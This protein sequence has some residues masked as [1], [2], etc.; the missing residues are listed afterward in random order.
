M[1]LTRLSCDV[2][3]I[4][5][6]DQHRLTSLQRSRLVKSTRKLSKI[7]GET[8]ATRITFASLES[9]PHSRDVTQEY[10]PI[11][12]LTNKLARTVFESIQVV[13]RRRQDSDSDGAHSTDSEPCS[14]PSPRG[15]APV[16]L[17]EA[18]NLA[19]VDCHHDDP[20]VSHNES[21]I[22][23]LFRRRRSRLSAISSSESPTE[24]EECEDERGARNR[25]QRLSKLTRYLGESIPSELILPNI[26]SKSKTNIPALTP[27]VVP[28]PS[29][30]PALEQ[31]T[32]FSTTS[33]LP[34]PAVASTVDS[35]MGSIGRSQ[36]HRFHADVNSSRFLVH[37]RRPR[38]ESTLSLSNQPLT[39]RPDTH[40]AADDHS[41]TP[42]LEDI[43]STVPSPLSEPR[44]GLIPPGVA[45]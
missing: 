29:T 36:S 16:L 27:P 28:K 22:G 2:P 37:N 3:T 18:P 39:L 7:L 21:P 17:F 43:N 40:F 41:D 33:P 12:H 34:K 32:L 26:T 1:P 25:R 11:V 8:P 19:L 42:I 20:Q 13:L 15:H 14:S 44:A 23:P 30:V 24:W 38:S 4:P 9:P 45:E 5:S 6:D 10:N 35:L 31:R